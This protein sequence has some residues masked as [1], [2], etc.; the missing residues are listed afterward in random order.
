MPINEVIQLFSQYP[1]DLILRILDDMGLKEAL[2]CP[3]DTVEKIEQALAKIQTKTKALKSGG[4]TAIAVSSPEVKDM[5]IEI[6]NDFSLGI[7]RKTISIAMS[8]LAVSA[9]NDADELTRVMNS[10]FVARVQQNQ[11]GFVKELTKAFTAQS[12]DFRT[13]AKA[14]A[15]EILKQATVDENEE[16]LKSLQD[17][18]TSEAKKLSSEPI[19][20]FS[21]EDD[22]F[23]LNAFM[24]ASGFLGYGE[25]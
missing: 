23:D 17:Y 11:E 25:K 6:E 8:T 14:I 13:S 22:G 16:E 2:E 20:P 19:N 7:S 9:I 21:N 24:K 15:G 12:A 5:A 10:V 1:Q 3:I 4:S 18:L